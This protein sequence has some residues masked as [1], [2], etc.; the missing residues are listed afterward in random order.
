MA[1]G[2]GIAFAPGALAQVRSLCGEVAFQLLRAVDQQGVPAFEL[3]RQQM[4]GALA[5]QRPHHAFQLRQIRRDI[6]FAQRL[7]C[8]RQQRALQRVQGDSTE[9]TRHAIAHR[10]DAGAALPITADGFQSL[11]RGIVAV[12]QCLPHQLPPALH[13]QGA[14]V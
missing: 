9:A 2:G 7:L 13:Q 14:V 1:D 8:R 12:F 11:Q 4:N 5:Q 10:I 3:R 6:A